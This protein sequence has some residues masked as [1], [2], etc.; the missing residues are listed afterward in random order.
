MNND[1]DRFT[2]P[3]AIFS[4]EDSNAVIQSIAF[5]DESLF[6]LKKLK[7]LSDLVEP[8]DIELRRNL[9]KNVRLHD[10]GI[11]RVKGNYD[12]IYL[13]TR[14]IFEDGK[15]PITF[16]NNHLVSLYN[17]GICDENTAIVIF[18]AH[19]DCKQEYQN[20]KFSKATWL[21]RFI[22]FS[23]PKQIALIGIRSLD[24][25]E[26]EF[27]DENEVFYL[28]S[29]EIK[30]DFSKSLEEFDKFMKNFE[31]VFVSFDVDVIDPSII[32]GVNFPEPLGLSLNDVFT[33]FESLREKK[34]RGID[35]VEFKHIKGMEMNEITITKIFYRLLDVTFG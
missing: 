19:A 8:F 31:S 10:K 20:K 7:E 9:L 26:L 3:A 18:D 13:R 21:R 33:F 2:F 24:E 35:I 34:F 30:N 17:V 1:K 25:E 11:F 4:Y 15:L 23:N 6:H 12:E 28:A 29:T 22:E 27:L 14:K 5:K 32:P 16:A